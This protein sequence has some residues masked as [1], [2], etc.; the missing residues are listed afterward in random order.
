M[1]VL[2]AALVLF[3]RWIFWPR[4]PRQGDPELVDRESVWRRIGST[5]ARKPPAF[6][7]GTLVALALMMG[8]ITQ[9]DTG[10]QQLATEPADIVKGT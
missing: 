1:L 5:V 9:I 6:V 3:G 2:P 10:L 8:G 7:A 4:I